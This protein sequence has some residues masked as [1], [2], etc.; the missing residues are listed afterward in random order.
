VLSLS[1]E[2]GIVNVGSPTISQPVAY[3]MPPLPSQGQLTQMSPEQ[4]AA[5][6]DL[7]GALLSPEILRPFDPKRKTRLINDFDGFEAEPSREP[8][9]G[10][11]LW[12]LHG[13]DWFPVGY[14]SRFLRKSEKNLIRRQSAFSSSIGESLAFDF[15]ETH[16]YPELSQVDSH[17]VLADARNLT[18]WKT[19]DSPLL[20]RLRA[21]LSG[22]YDITKITVRHIPRDKNFSDVLGRLSVLPLPTDDHEDISLSTYEYNAQELFEDNLSFNSS[23]SIP[24]FFLASD[25]SHEELKQFKDNKVGVRGPILRML[26]GRPSIWCRKQSAPSRCGMP[27]TS[28]TRR[29]RISK[30][31]ARKQT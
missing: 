25:F 1:P 15:G 6:Q 12:Q 14:A 22:R 8:A 4:E 19:S 30:R 5:F 28:L 23:S 26:H 3:E 2:R 27:L 13:A 11:S 18:Y 17:E 21:K 9:I 24:D 10:S 7:R 20:V 16:F 31:L 29:A